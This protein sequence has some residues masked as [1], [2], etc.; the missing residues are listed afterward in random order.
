MSTVFRK[1]SRPIL[2]RL[3]PGERVTEHG[4]TY[5][6]LADN[7]GLFTINIMVDGQR[8]HRTIGKESDGTT[9]KQAEDFIIRTKS[10][11]RSGRLN[12]PK[13]RKVV[14]SLAEAANRYLSR[15]T[16]EGGKDLKMKLQR[17]RLHILPALGN[18]PLSRLCSFDIDRYKKNRLDAGAK[19]G[20]VN[21][22]LAVLS[23]LFTK[24]EDWHWIDRRPVKIRKFQVDGA[25][26]FYLIPEEARRLVA[27]AE[28]DQNPNVHAF[29]MIA[30]DTA[31]R[32][33]EVLTIRK[34]DVDLARNII[35]IPKA[36]AGSREQPF[37]DDL[38][39]FL[40]SYMKSLPDDNPWLFPCS[41]SKTGHA[42]EIAKPFRRVVAAAGFDTRLV[43]RHTLRHTAISNMVQAGIDLP[44]VKR[45]SGHKTLKMV[46]RYAHQNGEHIQAA[47][48]KYQE[49]M[50]LASASSENEK[51]GTITQELHKTEKQGLARVS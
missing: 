20:T 38:K 30:T 16:E 12:L 29:I 31:M 26:L 47:M 40:K 28:R 22:E 32:K 23:H 42:T 6:K 46:E 3:A 36:K 21:L 13:G 24:A 1:L 11:A 15:L 27:F 44:T 9:R 35:H 48:A 10:D 19:K 34:E 5:E 8:I 4:I 33:T 37:T 39:V 49:R 2:R 45:F 41:G 17:L 51:Q 18:L 25:R 7:D 14:M 50:N 43:N